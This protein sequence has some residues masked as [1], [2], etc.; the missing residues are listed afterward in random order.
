V[1]YLVANVGLAFSNNFAALMVFRGIQAAG[2]AATISVGTFK[3]I[4]I[5][6]ISDIRPG[7]GVIGDITTAR[8]RGGLIG[9]FGGSKLTP[10]M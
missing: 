10:H 6:N 1:V 8:E 3:L 4:L 5:Q 2:S 7:A 9:I